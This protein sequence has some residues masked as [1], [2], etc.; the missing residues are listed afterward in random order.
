[1]PFTTPTQLNL[2]LSITGYFLADKAIIE[3]HMWTIYNTSMGT[4]I[5]SFLASNPTI[6][7]TFL[8]NDAQAGLGD[9]NIFY[10]LNFNDQR[11]GFVYIDANGVAVAEQDVGTIAHELNHALTGDVDTDWASQND[12]SGTNVTSVNPIFTEL[13]L[14]GQLSYPASAF[15]GT[16]TVGRDYSEGVSIARAWV[17]GGDGLILNHTST[18]NFND[19]LI[20]W[21]GVNVFLAGNGNDVIFGNGGADTLSGEGGDDRIFG[22]LGQ[23]IING[24]GG[25]DQLFGHERPGTMGAAVDDNVKDTLDGGAGD[26]KVYGGGGNDMIIAGAGNDEYY[27][28]QAVGVIGEASNDIDTVDYSAVGAGI[29]LD[30]SSLNA[31]DRS[32]GFFLISNDG[33]SGQDR[34][35]SI[36]KIIGTNQKDAF[37]FPDLFTVFPFKEIDGGGDEDTIDFTGQTNALN[38]TIG[39]GVGQLNLINIERF[40]LGDAADTLTFASNITNV[41]ITFIDGGAGMDTLDL[42]SSSGGMLTLG[43]GAG[44]LNLVNIETLKLTGLD[45]TITFLSGD[46]VGDLITIDG[47]AGNDTIDFTGATAGLDF[48]ELAAVSIERVLLTGFADYMEIEV[49][50]SSGQTIVIDGGGA[51]DDIYVSGA[52]AGVGGRAALFG[53]AGMD[54]LETNSLDADIYGNAGDD[55]IFL[56]AGTGSHVFGGAGDDGI[57]GEGVMLFGGAGSDTITSLGGETQLFGV[58]ING[59]VDTLGA[60]GTPPTGGGTQTVTDDGDVDTLIGGA[61]NDIA[62]AQYTHTKILSCHNVDANAC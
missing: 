17:E 42:S 56:T 9:G 20:G 30:S 16:L 10:D 57:S 25:D 40:I 45:D 39:T 23:D 21:T 52:G 44:E 37:K 59:L 28:Y 18:G 36:E 33:Q 29:T 60:N 5:D 26:D 14:P 15:D 8:L 31:A 27:G 6:N 43:T 46:A 3:G 48:L 55:I 62:M 12:Y 2:K 24:G 19:L 61:G 53:G 47:R 49:E 38:F 11:M 34:L 7:F 4:L 41:G 35:H 13:G 1:M 22:G 54:A 58:Y 51:D 50:P 32:N